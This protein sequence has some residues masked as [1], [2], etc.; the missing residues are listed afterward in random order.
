MT[1]KTKAIGIGAAV[2]I[3]LGAIAGSGKDKKEAAQEPTA[4]PVRAV[5]TAEPTDTPVP[6][7]TPYRIHRMDPERIV[8]VSNNGIIHVESDCSGM[9]NYT[10]MTLEEADAAG[11]DYCSKCCP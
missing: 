6:T 11:Y 8:Y 1:K 4:E 9:K 5:V 7:A 3:A 10:E 2:L